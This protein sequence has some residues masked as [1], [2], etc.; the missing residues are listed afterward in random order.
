MNIRVESLSWSF[1]I[2]R[3]FMPHAPSAFKAFIS[4]KKYPMYDGEK[5]N[6]G[7]SMYNT[8]TEFTVTNS[9]NRK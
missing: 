8:D 6:G 2:T 4:P 7:W 5:F 1:F 9:E 3:K